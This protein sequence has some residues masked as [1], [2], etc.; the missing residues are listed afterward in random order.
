MWSFPSLAAVEGQLWR[1]V[2]GTMPCVSHHHPCAASPLLYRPPSLT[3]VP[4]ECSGP[5]FTHTCTLCLCFACAILYNMQYCTSV[6]WAINCTFASLPSVSLLSSPPP[7][8]P[9]PFFLTSAFL[10]SFL[11][12]LSLIP[13]SLSSHPPCARSEERGVGKECRCRGWRYH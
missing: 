4:D 10:L 13:Y 1:R 7:L 11:S 5:L 2:Q 9:F 3:C 12:P 8:P 6:H